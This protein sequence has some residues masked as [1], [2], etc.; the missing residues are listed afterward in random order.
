MN[1]ED[2]LFLIQQSAKNGS[3]VSI[4]KANSNLHSTILSHLANP[5][6]FCSQNDAIVEPPYRGWSP[7]DDVRWC[8]AI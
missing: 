5:I 3:V 8:N 1:L 2:L 4:E 7:I 6:P